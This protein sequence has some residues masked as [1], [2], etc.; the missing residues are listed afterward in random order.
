MFFVCVCVLFHMCAFRV[1]A[2]T[3]PRGEVTRAPDGYN[4][5][6][7]TLRM[8]ARWLKA[9]TRIQV[10]VLVPSLPSC[11]TLGKILNHSELPHC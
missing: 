9:L 3:R 4:K 8:P 5:L 11:V 7:A 10:Q 6:E 2:V 1:T